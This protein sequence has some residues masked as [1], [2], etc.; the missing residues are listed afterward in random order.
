[1]VKKLLIIPILAMSVCCFAA[2]ADN[3]PS[4]S[5]MQLD[6]LSVATKVQSEKDRVRVEIENYGRKVISIYRFDKRVIWTLMPDEK[7]YIETPMPKS[8]KPNNRLSQSISI[9]VKE[10]TKVSPFEIPPG[11]EKTK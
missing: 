10:Q 2:F 9:S 6:N 7:T 5:F 8:S 1:M 3:F 4:L 11:Y